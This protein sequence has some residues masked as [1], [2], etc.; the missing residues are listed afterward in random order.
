MSLDGK[1]VSETDLSAIERCSRRTFPGAFLPRHLTHSP[2]N[3][4]Q[5]YISIL[6]VVLDFA[7]K[8]FACTQCV[9]FPKDIDA[10]RV[11]QIEPT[12]AVSAVAELDVT[13]FFQ[14]SHASTE[15]QRS[16][17]GSHIVRNSSRTRRGFPSTVQK[18]T[19]RT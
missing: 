16:I 8:H 6:Y 7:W 13:P 5:Q 19:N 4:T 1:T 15:I 11:L 9:Y 10:R 2:S 17:G 12:G 14:P 18:N 3:Q